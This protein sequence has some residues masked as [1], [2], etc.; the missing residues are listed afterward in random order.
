MIYTSQQRK[1]LNELEPEVI[2][3]Y[4]KR[5]WKLSGPHF[6]NFKS[7]EYPYQAFTYNH[8]ILEFYTAGSYKCK[9]PPKGEGQMKFLFLL[10]LL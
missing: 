3:H 7:M 9:L 1:I 6:D 2:T 10:G 4:K 8:D 5:G